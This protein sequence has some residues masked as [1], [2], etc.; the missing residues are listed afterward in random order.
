MQEQQDIEDAANG[1]KR[2]ININTPYVAEY[3]EWNKT[4][5]IIVTSFIFIIVMHYDRQVIL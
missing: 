1:Q 2:M 5:L 4:W 3:N